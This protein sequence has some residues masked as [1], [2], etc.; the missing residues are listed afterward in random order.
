MMFLLE[1]RCDLVVSEP[2]SSNTKMI[3]YECETGGQIEKVSFSA[4]VEFPV[5]HCFSWWL[6]LPDASTPQEI[7][8]PHKRAALVFWRK[9]SFETTWPL[10]DRSSLVP[11]QPSTPSAN[12][13]LTTSVTASPA[14]LSSASSSSPSTAAAA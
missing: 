12:A 9:S 13:S 7:Q 8:L 14:K 1:P 4:A 6:T 3:D 2:R 5:K 10:G 11:R